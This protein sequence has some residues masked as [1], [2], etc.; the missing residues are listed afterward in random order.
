MSR[1]IVHERVKGKRRERETEK[2]RENGRSA[3][4]GNFSL[5]LGSFSSLFRAR[6]MPV[7]EGVINNDLMSSNNG[8]H[9]WFPW[10]APSGGLQ[11]ITRRSFLPLAFFLRPALFACLA[12]SFFFLFLL[13]L[14]TPFTSPPRLIYTHVP[15]VDR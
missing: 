6:W 4:T 3:C 1:R 11:E 12:P 13:R 10:L 7:R 14:Y 5:S 8:H 2:P 9:G 15:V